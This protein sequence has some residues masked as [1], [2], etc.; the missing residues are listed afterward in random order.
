MLLVILGVIVAL[1]VV[2]MWPIDFVFGPN[3]MAFLAASLSS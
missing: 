2:V 3:A 1:N